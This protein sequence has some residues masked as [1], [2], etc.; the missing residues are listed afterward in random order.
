MTTMSRGC[1]VA[2]SARNPRGWSFKT[3]SSRTRVC[4]AWTRRLASAASVREAFAARG[5]VAD[6][7]CRILHGVEKVRR[8]IRRVAFVERIAVVVV[9]MR[10]TA[11]NPGRCGRA[12]RAADVRFRSTAIRR[13]AWR[14][15]ALFLDVVP[16]LAAWIGEIDVHVAVRGDGA[17]AVVHIGRQMADAEHV[18]RQRCRHRLSQPVRR[19]ARSCAAHDAARRCARGRRATDSPAMRSVRRRVPIRGACRR[20]RPDIG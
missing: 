2:S 11:K 18:Q 16:M 3:S 8:C 13:P 12:R 7:G 5:R 4:T 14:A 9:G 15:G 1:S 6:S 20:D 19:R 17:Q 10:A